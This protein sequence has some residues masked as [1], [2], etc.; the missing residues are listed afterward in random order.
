[1][2]VARIRPLHKGGD[3]KLKN[4][5]RPISIL[6]LISKVFEKLMYSRISCFLTD[7]DILCNHQFGFRSGLSTSDAIVKYLTVIQKFDKNSSE[8]LVS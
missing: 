4:N 2:K 7:N 6:S 3:S 5:Y 8:I 1:M